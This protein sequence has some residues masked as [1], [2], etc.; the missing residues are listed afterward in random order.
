[1][2]CKKII[3]LK[4]EKY[5]WLLSVRNTIHC[6]FEG[7]LFASFS[8]LIAKTYLIHFS[9]SI[10]CVGISSLNPPRSLPC[11]LFFMFCVLL[12]HRQPHI[13]FWV[14]ENFFYD[15]I[16]N[17]F[18]NY[19]L[20]FFSFLFSYSSQ[21]CCFIM[22]QFW[23]CFMLWVFFFFRFNLSFDRF[24]HFFYCVFNVYNSIFYLLYSLVDA[25]L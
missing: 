17:T 14:S 13:H 4:K 21:S 10:S 11:S 15:F 23:G 6:S 25:F 24:I 5:N 9:M 18:C 22:S 1:M 2:V 19:V 12:L 3:N 16:E 20:D 7:G 8:F